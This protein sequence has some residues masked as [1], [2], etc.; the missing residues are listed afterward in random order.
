MSLNKESTKKKK[1]NILTNDL[2]KELNIL[3]KKLREKKNELSAISRDILL[4]KEKSIF[5]HKE[6]EKTSNNIISLEKN[7]SLLIIKNDSIKS[8]QKIILNSINN[9]LVNFDNIFLKDDAKLKELLSIFFNFEN[10]F[11]EQLPKLLENNSD[12]TS[13][14]I[15]SYSYLKMLQNDVNQKYQQIKNKIN[16]IL[17]GIKESYN[18]TPFSLIINYIENI[19]KLL[20]NKEKINTFEKQNE[21]L[22]NKKNEIFIKLKI[23]EENKKEKEN[24]LNIIETYVNE[25]VSLIEAYKVYMRY[26]KTKIINK[27]KEK[28]KDKNSDN[29]NIKINIKKNENDLGNN[30]NIS[31]PNNPCFKKDKKISFNNEV[32]NTNNKI[33]YINIDLTNIYIEKENKINNKKTIDS[34]EDINSK[35]NISNYYNINDLEKDI[36]EHFEDLKSNP[37]FL[38]RINTNKINNNNNNICNSNSIISKYKILK[39]KNNKNAENKKKK[40]SSNKS[41]TKNKK[42]INNKN[43]NIN[44]NEQND[45]NQTNTNMTYNNNNILIN[46]SN[47]VNKDEISFD[48]NF[49]NGKINHYTSSNY[50][51][52]N[53]PN[54]K[55][56]KK[57]LQNKINK[58]GKMKLIPY[59]TQDYQSNKD[60]DKDK[61][62]PRKSNETKI[63]RKTSN[64]ESKN[65]FKTRS[66]LNSPNKDKRIININNNNKN[67]RIAA[68]LALNNLENLNFDTDQKLD[69]ANQSSYSK[70]SQKNI[71]ISIKHNKTN[72][73]RDNLKGEKNNREKRNRKSLNK[74]KVNISKKEIKKANVTTYMERKNSPSRQSPNFL[75]NI[76]NSDDNN[77]KNNINNR[78]KLNE[79]TKI[80][81]DLEKC[82]NKSPSIKQRQ[83]FN[84]F[85]KEEKNEN[86]EKDN[87]DSNNKY[88]NNSLNNNI[89]NKNCNIIPFKKYKTNRTKINYIIDKSNNSNIKNKMIKKNNNNDKNK[90]K[91]NISNTNNNNNKSQVVNNLMKKEINNYSFNKQDYKTHKSSYVKI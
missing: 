50:I 58:P 14:L 30:L 36:L 49:K 3:P 59:L 28:D 72:L 43:I 1:E 44:N 76:L 29:K 84:K 39:K 34:I 68:T 26:S 89:N 12:L 75:Q 60:K 18:N 79:I 10:G 71:Y 91:G 66:P 4:L 19:F 62:N 7:F 74:L 77:N 31:C 42:N 15:G 6:L 16:N 41:N 23:I 13:L 63:R 5:F 8:Q 82:K 22:N 83:Y 11:S 90:E 35:F 33:S 70:I 73:C 2:K 45:I 17:I 85:N 57:G 61:D 20:D 54:N 67:N 46:N 37:L 65:I 78:S 81:I 80:N 53:S 87:N 48:S 88:M 27:D 25:L 56:D 52:K 38:T 9:D 24:N 64:K 55:Q 86:K 47:E 21:S 32:R 40:T 51:K 69:K